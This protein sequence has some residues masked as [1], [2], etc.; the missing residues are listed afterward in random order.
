MGDDFYRSKDRTNSI[1]VLKEN[2]QRKKSD[3]ANNKIHICIVAYTMIDKK[4]YKY[5]AQQVP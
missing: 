3:N 1:K 4:G 5:T 2:V